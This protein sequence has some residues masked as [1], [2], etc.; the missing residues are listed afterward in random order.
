MNAGLIV[1]IT[2]ETD[3]IRTNSTLG[4]TLGSNGLTK[5]TNVEACLNTVYQINNWFRQD[6]FQ[7]VDWENALPIAAELIW[8]MSFSQNCGVGHQISNNIKMVYTASG[9]HCDTTAQEKTIEGALDKAFGTFIRGDKTGIWCIQLSHGGSWNGFLLIGPDTNWPGYI[10]C[11]SGGKDT[12][13][14]GGKNDVGKFNGRE[15]TRFLLANGAEAGLE[16]GG[17]YYKEATS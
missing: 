4:S 12:C 16:N 15:E 6:G 11:G 13:V 2:G 10:W 17:L 1:D 7:W 14:S 8:M 9:A 3:P 5:R